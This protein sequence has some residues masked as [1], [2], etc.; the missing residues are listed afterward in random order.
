M[1]VADQHRFTF[2][3]RLRLLQPIHDQRAAGADDIEDTVGQADAGSDL[4]AASQLFDRHIDA[5]H[6][7]ELTKCPGIAGSNTLAIEVIQ[8]RVL[9]ILRY[10]Q[11]E[12]TVAEAQL[13]HHLYILLF[14]PHFILTQ[15]A[16]V[17]HT[18]F[19]ILRDII[20]TKKEDLHGE[21]TCI[22]L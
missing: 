7:K 4:H 2:D 9:F 14:L 20:I 15:D 12:T 18:L 13:L 6:L 3:D 21:V 1:L 16:D 22:G 10:G 5:L 17:G 11:R 19:H 8:S